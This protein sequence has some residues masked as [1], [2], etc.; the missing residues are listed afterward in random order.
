MKLGDVLP[1]WIFRER[2]GIEISAFAHMVEDDA[3]EYVFIDVDSPL[4]GLFVG[5]RDGDG[6]ADYMQNFTELDNGRLFL[7]HGGPGNLVLGLSVL[8]ET[9]L[10]LAAHADGSLHWGD[11]T[12]PADVSLFRSA[13][14]GSLVVGD[15]AAA[16]A[17]FSPGEMGVTAANNTD[18][19]D[20]DA[21]TGRVAVYKHGGAVQL[22]SPNGTTYL[23]TVTNAGVINV[24]AP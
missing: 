6:A 23:V 18:Y 15:E 10:R 17:Y 14:G 12:N 1:H 9:Q 5:Y 19:I 11:G 16:N 22:Q 21:T 20:L 3:H 7:G 2:A 13:G 4:S 24:A 8:G